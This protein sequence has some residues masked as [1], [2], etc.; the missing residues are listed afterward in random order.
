MRFAALESSSQGAYFLFCRTIVAVL[1]Y[2]VKKTSKVKAILKTCLF[3]FSLVEIYT[4]P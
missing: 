2:M 3:S 1:G 4:I